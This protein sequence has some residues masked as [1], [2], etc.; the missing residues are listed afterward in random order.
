MSSLFDSDIKGVPLMKGVNEGNAGVRRFLT[1]SS[2]A[3]TE[4]GVKSARANIY[5]HQ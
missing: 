5:G 2:S 3:T 4:S 1:V